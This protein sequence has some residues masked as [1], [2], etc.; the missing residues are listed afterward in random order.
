MDL[1]KFKSIKKISN[2][3]IALSYNKVCNQ[4][5]SLFLFLQ[6]TCKNKNRH[7]SCKQFSNKQPQMYSADQIILK[8]IFLFLHA[9]GISVTA[10]PPPLIAAVID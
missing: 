1:L 7:R 9:G 8:T 3:V 6:G 10:M 5:L 2:E 4:I